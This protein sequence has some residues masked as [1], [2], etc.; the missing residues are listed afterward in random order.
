MNNNLTTRLGK[1]E[2]ATPKNGFWVTPWP[3]FYGRNCE[4]VWQDTPPGSL[5]DFYESGCNYCPGCTAVHCKMNSNV[6]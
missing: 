3:K 2:D 4:P 1:L 5:S 6:D